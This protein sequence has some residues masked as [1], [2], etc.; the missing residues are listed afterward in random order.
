MRLASNKLPL[1]TKFV[2]AAGRRKDSGRGE[3]E[4]SF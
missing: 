2:H 1:R 4:C 3:V